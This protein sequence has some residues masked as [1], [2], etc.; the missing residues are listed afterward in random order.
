LA[1]P[2]WAEDPGERSG[3]KPFYSIPANSLLFSSEGTCK[4]EARIKTGFEHLNMNFDLNLP[5]SGIFGVELAVPPSPIKLDLKDPD[6][7]VGRLETELT[8]LD[9]YGIFLSGD[10]AIP[11]T[12]RAETLAEPFWAGFFPVNWGG[13]D[14]Q[15][16]SIESGLVY[17]FRPWVSFLAGF[18]WS[19]FSLDLKDPRDT[20]GEIQLFHQIFGDVYTSDMQTDFYIPYLGVRMEPFEKTRFRLTFL[21]SPFAFADFTQEFSYKFFATPTLVFYERENV[22]MNKFGNFLEGGIEYEV[23]LS[24][25]TALGFWVKGDY[26]V[27]N[28]PANQTY[29][30]NALPFFSSTATALGGGHLDVS[31]ISGGATISF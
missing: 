16:Y 21:F 1:S 18:R 5:F 26:L 19:H 27:V 15:W 4:I 13:S 6:F 30:A 22:S 23:P 9:K 10:A 28:G 11:K 12:V 2:A 7:W 31:A 24:K 3:D 29:T 14:F 25:R 20:V 17:R 8:L